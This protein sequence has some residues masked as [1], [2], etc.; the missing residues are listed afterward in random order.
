MQATT[1]SAAAAAAA[2]NHI[3]VA[4]KPITIVNPN[5][6]G[7]APA[8]AVNSATAA[9]ANNKDLNPKV[10]INKLTRQENEKSVA[11]ATTKSTTSTK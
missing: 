9:T 6:I 2:S 4:R 10:Q 11:A 8:S 3:F 1:S 7:V 5:S